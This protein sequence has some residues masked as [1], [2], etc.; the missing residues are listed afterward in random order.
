MDGI[1]E[2]FH[3]GG[4]WM[5]PILFCSLVGIAI[6]VE[7]VK[8]LR[9]ASS[10]KKDELLQHINSHIL[11]G[12]LDKAIS[13]TSQI[14]NPLTNIVSAGLVAVANGKT[15]EEVQTA[16]DAV[17][18]REVP[19]ITKRV[20]LLSTISNMATLFGL[21]GTVVGMIGAFAAV[22]GV[23]ASEKASLL[24]SAIAESMNCTAFGLIVAIPTLGLY[25]W[26]NSWSTDLVD[27]IHETSVKTLNF[28][29]SNRNK[30]G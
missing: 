11:Q 8:T 16:M 5:Y 20:S 25:G 9:A 22:A 30:I 1:L 21:L 6:F 26:L 12:H 3:E 14:R 7:R 13:I 27:N 29:L 4:I 10:V 19:L 24:A 18:L 23:S 28:I 17:A 15:D 2:K